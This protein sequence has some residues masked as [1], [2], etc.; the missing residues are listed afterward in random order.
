MKFLPGLVLS[1]ALLVG[2]AP[3]AEAADRIGS[4]SRLQGAAIATLEGASRPLKVGADLFVGDKITT[5]ASSRIEMRL[6]DETSITLGDHSVFTLDEL[7]ASESGGSAAFDM[8]RGVL[9]IITGELADTDRDA[10]TITTPAGTIGFR[11]TIAWGSQDIDSLQVTMLDGV[12]VTVTTPA[13]SVTISQAL[14]GT[15]VARPGAAP[16]QP[17]RWSDERLERAKATVAFDQ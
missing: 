7:S 5:G 17:S 16:T 9:L 1:I 10:Y 6:T 14:D 2:G 11:G 12:S 15:A 4:V 8:L 13:G 3:M